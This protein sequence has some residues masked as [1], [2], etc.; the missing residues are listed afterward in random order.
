ML[1][2]TLTAASGAQ[3]AAAPQLDVYVGKFNAAQ[4][5]A[6]AEFGIDRHEIKILSAERGKVG[7]RVEVILTGAQADKLAAQGIEIE[8][9]KVD[10]QT[11]SQR[12][13]R[14]AAEGYEVFKRYDE[15]KAEVTRAARK[16]WPIAKLVNV[17]K[18][19][20]GKD[21]VAIKITLGAPLTRDGSKPAAMYIGAQ[22]A[23]EWITPEMNLRL[24]RHLLENY[25]RDRKVRE[26]VNT[27]EL[28]IVPV[29]NPDGYD[30]TFEE[31]QR[32]WRKNLRDNNGNGQ[33]DPAEGVDLNRN[34][35]Y[36]WGYD[37]EGSSPDPTSDTYRG[38]A[39]TSEPEN[40]ALESLVR[41]VTPEFFVNYHSAASL[42]LYGV[43]WQVATPSPDDLIGEALAGDDAEPAVPGYDP[44]LSAELYTTNGDTD[45]H[46]Q[47]NFGAY[48]F[49]PEMGTCADAANSVPD[50][51]WVAEDCV[52]DF[53]FPDDEALI[54]AEF[55]KNLPFALSVAE[56]ADDPANPESAIG[57]ETPDFVPDTFEVSYGDPQ[58][59]A[60]TAKR[61]LERL[62]LHYRINNGRTRTASVSEWRGGE[63]FGDEMRRYFA[64]YRGE[65]R[66]ARAGDRVK[67]WFSGEKRGKHP[68]RDEEVE[69]APFT[70]TVKQDTGAKV[71]VIANEDYT[72]YNPDEAPYSGAPRYAQ[73]HVDAVRAAGYS[74]DLWDVDK[75]GVPHD[76]GVL[77]HY[78]AVLWYVGDNR[79][80]QDEEDYLTFNAGPS[81]WVGNLPDVA[82]AER[83]QYLTLAVRSYLNEGGKLLHA[84]EMA[85]DYGLIEVYTE[86][87]YYGLNGD[88]GADC[89]LTSGV[90]AIYDDCLILA[91]D[92]R[93]YWLGAFSRVAL[94][95]VTAFEG[96]ANPIAG[97]TGEL[98]G[99]ATNALD[100]P[101]SFQPTSEVLPVSQ[102]PQFKSWGAA[103]YDLEG[104]PFEPI[105]GTRYAAATHADASY[106]RLTKTFD[107]TG[108]TAAQAPELAAQMS[109]S[110]EEG[111]DHVIVEAR[112]AGGSNWTTLAE[113]SGATSTAVPA[114]CEAGYLLELHPTLTRYL[115]PGDPCTTKGNWN[116]L[117]GE[118]DG[119]QKMEFDLS[120]FAGQRVEV[121][122]SYVTDPVT[123]GVGVFVDDTALE[124][125]TTR[126]QADGFE[127]ATSTWTVQGP[128]EGSPE[129]AGDFVIGPKAVSFYAGTATDDTLLLGFGLEQVTDSADR[130]A[131]V[132]RALG[133]LGVR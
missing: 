75:Q 61:E 74:V 84:S 44:D 54:Q 1:A 95:D 71:L 98:A 118:T 49:T 108:V 60:V 52:S 89:R 101:G 3:A 111:Y 18:S 119:W 8:A 12:A 67:V 117:T 131:L 80:T 7:A 34:F 86:G 6:L 35:A 77:K 109:I 82:V 115:T 79:Y 56:S 62:K 4:M 42:L 14:Q 76:L 51:E 41:R 102:F 126:S 107:L 70:Y 113:K 20:Q 78:K 38:P 68:W 121:T 87:L 104:S 9:K 23:R 127:G 50:D 85:Q 25:T 63:R 55:E 43:G 31:G 15:I 106:Q 19:V 123:G 132:R 66:G 39:P 64:E 30:H 97:L 103:T 17:G 33:I 28:W 122:I 40:K 53:I 130:V 22:H 10:G 90:Y 48:G 26:L 36:R 93:Q 125:G 120:A 114:E 46:M 72:G 124:V 100:E 16:H 105:E 32:L 91:N 27:R 92:F 29:A 88:P 21:I 112:T 96:I 58:T 24:M 59:V 133:G 69:S 110:T 65:V 73:A 99:T 37:N 2:A 47:E 11:A 129:N 116:S 13:T 94:E 57:R 5:K 128:P 81:L 45:T 83:Q